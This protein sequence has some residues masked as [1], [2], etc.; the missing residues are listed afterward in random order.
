MRKPYKRKSVEERFMKFVEFDTNNGCWLWTGSLY[1][2]GYGKFSIGYETVRATHL[3]LE[4]FKRQIKPEGMIVSHSCNTPACVNPDH[5][6]YDTH[7]NNMK[8]MV[9]CDRQNK[10][11]DHHAAKLDNDKVR[12]IR[13]KLATGKTLITIANEYGVSKKTILNIKQGKLWKHVS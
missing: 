10:G 9:E 5:L 12:E 13:L 4:L 1:H 7:V 11:I 6:S 2:N 8:Y 3:A